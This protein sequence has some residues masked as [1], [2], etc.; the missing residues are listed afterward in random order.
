MSA[1]VIDGTSGVVDWDGV[2]PPPG[3]FGTDGRAGPGHAHGAMSHHDGAMPTAEPQRLTPTDLAVL[4]PEDHGWPQDLGL[5]S[6]L[7]AAALHDAD[8]RFRIDV[9][10]RHVAGRVDRLPSRF[11]KRLVRPPVGL[12]GPYWVDH[13][14]VDVTAH[15]TEVAVPPPGDEAAL[16]RTCEQLRRRG[17]DRS[18]PLW[19]LSLLTGL[20]DGQVAMLLQVHHCVAD[21]MSG[22]A[23]LAAFVDDATDP[24]ADAGA[25]SDVDPP[26]AADVA[27]TSRVAPPAHAA[28]PSTAALLRDALRRDA[29]TLLRVVSAAAH[30]RASWTRAID[31]VRALRAAMA[32]V[33]T[34]RTSLNHRPI[35]R[36]R[37]V[38]LVRGDLAG[39]KATAHAHNATVNDVLLSAVAGGLRALLTARGEPVDDLVLRAAVPVALHHRGTTRAEGNA[40]GGLLLHLCVS[41]PDDR[42]R[43]RRI[44]AHTAERKRTAV[45]PGATRGAFAT[46]LAQRLLIRLTARQTMSNTYVANVPGPPIRLS[47]AGAPIT[48]MLP[49]VPL[50]GNLSVGVGALSYAGQ[51][52]LAVV[53]D[54]DTCPDIAIAAAGI[55]RS[56]TA[57]TGAI[58]AS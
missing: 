29:R 2:A 3:P 9:V 43:L 11:R 54:R 30:A 42:T 6:V 33:P 4:W 35:G 24:T 8:G 49:I 18:R 52:N 57:M 46:P 27:S 39:I 53:A 21:G 28:V 44:A 13:A 7:D 51:F 5:L 10:R 16:L 1:L 55:D 32:G 14:D 34:T 41:E 50:L 48:E 15:V 38:A 58:P 40:D 31:D 25:P 45:M 19:Q 56:L 36:D 12:G 26:A 37:H 22:I 17:L 47:M 20:G 23:A